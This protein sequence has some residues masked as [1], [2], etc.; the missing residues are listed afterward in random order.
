MATCSPIRVQ[1]GLRLTGIWHAS[2]LAL[3]PDMRSAFKRE[4]FI[5]RRAQPNDEMGWIMLRVAQLVSAAALISFYGLQSASAEPIFITAGSFSRTISGAAGDA[6][7]TGQLSGT[8][9]FSL[10]GFFG[11]EAFPGQLSACG[12]FC[13]PGTTF[14]YNESTSGTDL[15][16]TISFLG[17]SYTSG[18]E[19]DK[20]A[21]LG[22]YVLGL[23]PLVFPAG[24]PP[25]QTAMLSIPVQLKGILHVP[26]LPST[27]VFGRGTLDVFL[28]SIVEPGL[29]HGW[30]ATSLEYRFQPTAEPTPEPA[31]LLL[32]G[33]GLAAMF[34]RRRSALRR[35]NA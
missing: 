23:E 8:Q 25:G 13:V 22:L 28:L 10:T 17:A 15:T 34:A 5:L 35:S 30:R 16:G 3:A 27:G 4:D 26:Q 2:S 7:G 12:D 14:V 32:I 18:G 29:P 1:Q 24:A 33:G 6:P 9:G 19:S 31:S 11:R 21:Y 20:N